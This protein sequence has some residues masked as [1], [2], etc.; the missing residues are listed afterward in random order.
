MKVAYDPAFLSKDD[1]V[2]IKH[3]KCDIEII[4][5]DL[6]PKTPQNDLILATCLLMIKE[7]AVGVVSSFIYDMIKTSFKNFK[8]Q[9]RYWI[10]SSNKKTPSL[11]KISISAEKN[12]TVDLI[13]KRE[14]TEIEWLNINDT[15]K[16]LI[17]DHY[18]IQLNEDGRINIWTDLEYGRCQYEKRV[19]KSRSRK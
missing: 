10:D 4:E 15:I 13:L 18:I 12:K 6:N 14:P 2:K 5:R 17:K 7:V 9:P 3:H 8:K 19:R 11:A 16:H 1:I